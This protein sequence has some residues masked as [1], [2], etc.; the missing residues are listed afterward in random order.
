MSAIPAARAVGET[1]SVTGIDFAPGLVDRARANATATGVGNL[2]FEVA[3]VTTVDWTTHPPYDALLCA[4]G[5]FFLPSMD[6]DTARLITAL[7]PGGTIG[8]AVWHDVALRRFIT[9]FHE[10]AARAHGQSPVPPPD[11]APE[12]PL[13]R[14][15]TAPRMT[16][17]LTSIGAE[18]ISTEVIRL[19][20]PATDD[21]AWSMVLGSG[22][23]GALTGLHDRDIDRLRS[24]FL[25][26]LA[27]SGMT[28]ID[29]DVLIATGRRPPEE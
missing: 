18:S 20:N 22:L 7:R 25:Q 24:E 5:V 29:C 8:L 9:L 10:N 15:A 4:F 14:I 23:R 2:A 26:S 13:S 19:R 27:A 3:D 12:P 17:W 16:A 6:A 1:G 28:E 11:D 21:F